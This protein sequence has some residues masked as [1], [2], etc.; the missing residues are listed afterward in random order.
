MHFS[1]Y[2][3]S[4]FLC[5]LPFYSIVLILVRVLMPILAQYSCPVQVKLCSATVSQNQHNKQDSTRTILSTVLISLE[6]QR[7]H[8]DPRARGTGQSYKK[9]SKERKNTRNQ[10]LIG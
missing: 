10:E 7:N 1:T 8:L 5:I 9:P 2:L 4:F 3:T 6:Q